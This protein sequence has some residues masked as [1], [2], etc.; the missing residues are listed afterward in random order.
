M[1]FACCIAPALSPS[2]QKVMHRFEQGGKIRCWWRF[3]R[4]NGIRDA[5]LSQRD[6]IHIA[7]GDQQ[8]VERSVGL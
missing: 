7:F 3:Q 4:G 1:V 6:G 5:V 8:A 2:K